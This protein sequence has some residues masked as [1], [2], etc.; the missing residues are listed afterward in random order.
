MSNE[1]KA[2]TPHPIVEKLAADPAE[3]LHTVQFV[4][5][6]GTSTRP[7]HHRLYTSLQLDSYLDIPFAAVVC[8]E[9]VPDTEI[10]HGGTRVWV[11]AAATVIHETRQTTRTEARFLEGSIADEYLQEGTAGPDGGDQRFGTAVTRVITC[12]IACRPT[13]VGASCPAPCTVISLPVRCSLACPS[14]VVSCP[15]RTCNARLCTPA[16]PIYTPAGNVD[17]S[18]D[19]PIKLRP[20]VGDPVEDGPVIRQ[21][22]AAA[23]FGAGYGQGHGYQGPYGQPPWYRYRRGFPRRRR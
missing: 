21:G 17:P 20:G 1:K 9:D 18:P 13:I 22:N 15:P 8:H 10:A 5:Y 23:A 6:V 19:C 16:C 4:G 14:R 3:P 11:D 7:E 2:L 12:G